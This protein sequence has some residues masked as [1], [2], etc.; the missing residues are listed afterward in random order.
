MMHMAKRRWCGAAAGAF[1]GL[2]LIL[3]FW[4]MPQHRIKPYTAT[5]II[6][7]LSVFAALGAIVGAS[8]EAIIRALSEAE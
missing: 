8:V 5:E 1:G 2:I 4:P 3:F 7:N 6:L